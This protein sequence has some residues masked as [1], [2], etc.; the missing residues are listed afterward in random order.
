MPQQICGEGFIIK[1][2]WFSSSARLDAA[3]ARAAMEAVSIVTK[4]SI[5]SYSRSLSFL[6]MTVSRFSSVRSWMQRENLY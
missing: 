4:V 3:S 1:A 6:V 5:C 2:S